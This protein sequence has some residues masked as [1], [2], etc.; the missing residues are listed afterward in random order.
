MIG[1]ACK[2]GS[3]FAACVE[4]HVDA[5]WEL[6]QFYYKA[7]GCEIVQIENVTLKSCTCEHCVT[8]KHDFEALIE[9]V[10]QN[11]CDKQ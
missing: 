8:L 4:N 10:I 5:E 3:V 1:I 2:N 9:K 7:Q 6:E 11:H